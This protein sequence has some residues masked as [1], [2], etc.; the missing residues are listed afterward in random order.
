M[1]SIFYLLVRILAV[2]LNN[3]DQNLQIFNVMLH[4]SG[5]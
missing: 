4:V 2:L 1:E 5:N 3:L